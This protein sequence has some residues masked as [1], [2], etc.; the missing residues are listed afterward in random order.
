M[1]GTSNGRRSS[2]AEITT[3]LAQLA[4]GL[5]ALP[6]LG[7]IFFG[8]ARAEEARVLP[9]PAL[10]E[11]SSVSSETAVLA[12]GCFWGMQGVFEHVKGVTKVLAGY[13]GGD[14]STAE[15]ETVGSGG[16]GHAESVQITFDPRQISYGEILRIYFS[17][18]HDPT[19]LNRQGPDEGTQ[20]RSEIFFSSAMQENV[21]K[22]YVAQLGKGK[23]FS[24]PIATKMEPL[25]GFY[26]AEAYHQD[27][28]THHPESL[29]IQ[30]NDLPKVE[31]LKRLYPQL[32]RASPV[33]V[34]ASR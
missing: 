34:T 10:D 12:G 26:P 13:S 29:Y 7:V 6:L 30:V 4:L 28:L 9:P 27:Y 17:V 22:S 23:R 8:L 21:A 2:V 11:R 15:Y 18:G 25:H 33:L 16:T 24:A 1:N 32:Y 5:L 14:K 19:Q 20:Y 3:I 31:Q